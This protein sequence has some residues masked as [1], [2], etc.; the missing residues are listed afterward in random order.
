MAVLCLCALQWAQ[1]DSMCNHGN[2]STERRRSR[3]LIVADVVCSSKCWPDDF[4]A[5]TNI[6]SIASVP[7]WQTCSVGRR[8]SNG[9]MFLTRFYRYKVVCRCIPVPCGPGRDLAVKPLLGLNDTLNT[10]HIWVN[11]VLFSL[12]IASLSTRNNPVMHYPWC[13]ICCWCPILL[14]AR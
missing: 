11:H 7:F 2:H 10:L 9:F 3:F 6:F 13:W 5:I 14:D 12:N 8:I 4:G 1:I